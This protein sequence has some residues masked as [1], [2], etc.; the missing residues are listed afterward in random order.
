[1]SGVEGLFYV[2]LGFV[3]E[4]AQTKKASGHFEHVTTNFKTALQR[5][6]IQHLL[7]GLSHK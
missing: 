5:H 2:R 4:Q 3:W 1:M 6:Y 7:T